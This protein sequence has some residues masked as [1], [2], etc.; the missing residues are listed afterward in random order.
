MKDANRSDSTNENE[1]PVR[2]S[3][4]EDVEITECGL[5]FEEIAWADGFKFVAGVDEVGRGCLAGPVVAAAC[6]LDPAKPLPEGLNDSKQ[7]AAK[8]REEIAEELRETSLA[9]AIGSVDADEIDRINILEAT[10]LAMHRAIAALS[11]SADFLLVDALVLKGLGIGQRSIIKG[12][13]ISASIAAASIIAKTY[14]DGLMHAYDLEFPQYGFAAHVGYAT[15]TH[16]EAIKNHGSCHLHRQTF[17]GVAK[18]EENSLP[19]DLKVV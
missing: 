1:S 10:K 3:L 15:K 11:P 9:F 7:V 16:L 4:F 14:R 6:I 18:K 8:Q 5:V 12:D 2:V 17:H 13:S 19:S